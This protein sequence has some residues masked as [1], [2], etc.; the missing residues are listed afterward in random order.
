MDQF[1]VPQFIEREPKVVGPLTF[2]QFIMVGAAAGV[3]FFLYF[4]APFYFF[5]L[6]GIFSLTVASLLAFFKINGRPLLVVLKNMVLFS[7]APKLYLWRKKTGAPPKFVQTVRPIE[8]EIKKADV[9]TVAG[10]SRLKNLSTQIET[11]R[12]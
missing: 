11:K 10:K 2:K 1:T 7:L 8:D 9:P 12:K 6:G 4:T 5:I 3:S